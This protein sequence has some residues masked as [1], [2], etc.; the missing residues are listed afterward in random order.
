MAQFD[1]HVH[2]AISDGTDSPAELVRKAHLQGIDIIGLVDHDTSESWNEADRAGSELGVTVIGG[3][4]LSTSYQ[5]ISGHLL[6]YLPDPENPELRD[7]MGKVIKSRH[8]RFYEMA[9]RLKEDYPRLELVEFEGNNLA[10][11]RPLGRPHL[12]DAL[13]ALEYFPNRD[14]VFAQ[15]L[16]PDSPYYVRQWAPHPAEMVEV[17]RRAGGVPVWAHPLSGR[18]RYHFPSE[19]LSDM[20]DA[21][22]FGLERDH[23]EHDG[24]VREKVSQLAKKWKLE[25]TGGSD[26]HGNGKPNRLGENLTSTPVLHRIIKEGK[27]EGLLGNKL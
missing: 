9:V 8:G 13:V 21:G 26:Y 22:L 6:A 15:V 17:V 4:E 25:V 20:V 24:Q 3:M 12:A 14:A 1:A 10:D 27:I 16:R 19:A 23:R 2:T 11:G 5:G 18:Q 7:L